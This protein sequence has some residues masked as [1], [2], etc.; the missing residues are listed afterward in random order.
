[1]L[2]PGSERDRYENDYNNWPAELG[3]PFVDV[4]GDG[5]F[6]RGIDKPKFLGDVTAWCV[7]NDLDTTRTKN[8]INSGKLGL[9]FQF[10]VFGF[11]EDSLQNV[12]FKRIKIINKGNNTIENS[13]FSIFADFDLGSFCDDNVGCD[14]TL[15]L[16]IGY[17]GKGTDPLY[18]IPPAIGYQLLSGPR[19]EGSSTDTAIVEGKI[20]PGFKNL[21]MTSFSPVLKYWRTGIMDAGSKEEL[22]NNINGLTNFDGV[23]L[24]NPLTGMETLFGLS[25]D[26]VN[27]I[28]WYEGL[29]WPG[30]P[31]PYERRMYVN[32]GTFTLAPGDTQTVDFA[33]L[34]ARGEDRLLSVK[35]LKKEAE[36]IRTFYEKNFKKRIAPLNVT[37]NQLVLYQ[38]FPNP[39][40][41]VTNV[42]YY[43]PDKSEVVFN[44]YDVLGR[45][46][47]KMNRGTEVRGYHKFSFSNENLASGV[48]FYR[49]TAGEYSQIR[50]M[51]I[52]K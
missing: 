11:D 12:I 19:V 15:N 45:E 6:E 4:N 52:L 33:V 32:S 23:P 2:P 42:S 14:T 34:M 44:V 22:F 26:P 24:K 7:S 27:G 29:G 17:N 37:E 21:E 38:N 3:A 1:M 28:G 25:G 40:N 36:Y 31:L 48:Y 13:V 16:G 41:G 20:Y 30:G 10:T 39:F 5:I 50:K 47:V 51:M 18:G 9:E 46:V 8:L 49:I 35:E 43:L